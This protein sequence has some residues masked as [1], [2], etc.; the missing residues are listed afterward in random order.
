M[1]LAVQMVLFVWLVVRTILR[2]Q[3]RS[4]IVESGALSV[5][6]G[7]TGMMQQWSVNSWDSREQVGSALETSTAVHI[8][9]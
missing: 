6:T 2:G 4:V 3:W 7:G 5:M 9:E 1:I 8:G